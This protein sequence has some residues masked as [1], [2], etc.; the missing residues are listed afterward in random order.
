[1]F[2]IGLVKLVSDQVLISVIHAIA[3]HHEHCLIRKLE[4]VVS[5][6]NFALEIQTDVNHYAK[7]DV[8]SVRARMI[9]IHAN[10]VLLATS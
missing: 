1:M 7:M 5:V 9:V 10:Y 2:A 8:N 4:V 3:M 6:M